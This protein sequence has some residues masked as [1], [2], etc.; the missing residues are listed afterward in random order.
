MPYYEVNIKGFHR[1]KATNS[2]QAALIAVQAAYKE[3]LKNTNWH[4][5]R[6]N[7][8]YDTKVKSDYQ[9][10]IVQQSDEQRHKLQYKRITVKL[11]IEKQKGKNHL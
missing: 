4:I 1:V 7:L 6:T 2:G 9:I 3:L 8:G 10:I 5:E 11:I